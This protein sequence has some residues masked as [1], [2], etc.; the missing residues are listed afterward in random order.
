MLGA[1]TLWQSNMA[2]ENGAPFPISASK[3]L[4]RRR[5]ILVRETTYPGNVE[6]K[7]FS[8]GVRVWLFGNPPQPWWNPVGWQ[9]NGHWLMRL[10]VL[11]LWDLYT[12]RCQHGHGWPPFHHSRTYQ[13]QQP[14][15]ASMN[16]PLSLMLHSFLPIDC[17]KRLSPQM[18][19]LGE[20]TNTTTRD[21]FLLNIKLKWELGYPAK[22][23]QV[24]HWVYQWGCPQPSQ[25]VNHE[26]CS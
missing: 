1:I 5:V 23:E 6:W 11:M 16:R 24:S 21:G 17:G 12:E 10:Q 4:D 14:I 3:L 7:L 20:K 22:K 25:H 15:H 19:D 26:N 18:L 9:Q 8:V 2:M 13:L